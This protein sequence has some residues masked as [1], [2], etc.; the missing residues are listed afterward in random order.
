MATAM[1]YSWTASVA[2]AA[3]VSQHTLVNF[4]VVQCMLLCCCC[5]E[6]LR[7]LLLFCSAFLFSFELST[8]AV[9]GFH[10]A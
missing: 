1:I 5:S 7:C 10:A 2:Q 6:P 9:V 4:M 8:A 3:D